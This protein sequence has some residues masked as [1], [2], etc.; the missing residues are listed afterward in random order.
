M[1]RR[2]VMAATLAVVAGLLAL[3]GVTAALV[4]APD[5]GEV[6][7]RY[8]ALGDS[9]TSGPFIPDQASAPP[10]CRRS[11]RNYPRLVAARL[12]ASLRDV[13]CTGATTVHMTEPQ[14]LRGGERNRPQLAAVTPGTDLVSI[15]I[16]GNDAGFGA[17]VHDCLAAAP[18]ARPC[19]Q[20]YAG[21]AGDE[22]SRR[23]A[24]VAERIDAVLA[25]LRR[26]APRAR[27]YLVGYPAILPDSGT[28]CWSVLPIVAADVPYLRDK[29][30]E[31]NAMLAARAAAGGATFVDTY[32]PSVGHDACAAP[33]VRWV[34]P[35]APVAPAAPIHPNQAGMRAT[36]RAVVRAM[37]GP[38]AARAAGHAARTGP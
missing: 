9:Y 36:A 14:S 7:V 33:D 3:G 15:G 1:A 11:T 25:E 5:D 17:V 29:A 28:G 24:Q 2:Q 27:V 26:R 6:V 12:G 19:Q 20:V 31:L 13:S 30:R 4:T 16:G 8:A 23:I 21:P 22:I 38:S 37:G 32:G 18:S 10:R 35:L 34:E